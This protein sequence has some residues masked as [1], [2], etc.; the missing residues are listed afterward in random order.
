LYHFS[1]PDCSSKTK[2]K[3]HRQSGI[4]ALKQRVVSV[5]HGEITMAQTICSRCHKPLGRKER[6]M[7]SL[8]CAA[9]DAQLHPKVQT[10]PRQSNPALGSQNV[11][12]S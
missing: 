12:K 1:K 2:N 6:S 3:A 8:V 5:P 4:S 9:C 7:G 10:L 11:K